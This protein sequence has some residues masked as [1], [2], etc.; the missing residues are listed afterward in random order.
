MTNPPLPPELAAAAVVVAGLTNWITDEDWDRLVGPW[1]GF[2]ISL[3]LCALLLRHSAK[4]IRREDDRAK[5]DALER[6]TMHKESLEAMKET[7]SKFDVLSN[8]QME[9]QLKT[10]EALLLLSNSNTNLHEEMRR[11]KC[12]LDKDNHNHKI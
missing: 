6:K 10:A 12:L 4:R 1:G 7:H 3:M 9:C 2:L 5:E 11:R 8:K